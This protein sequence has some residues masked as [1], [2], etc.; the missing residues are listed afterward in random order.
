MQC[1]A[2]PLHTS[3]NHSH[4][5]WLTVSSGFIA[6]WKCKVCGQ[7]WSTAIS[8]RKKGTGCPFC[9]GRRP[10][11]GR[12]DL[13]TLRPDLATE[14][15]HDANE[16]DPDQ[17]TVSSGQKVF[18]K[19]KT[20]GQSWRATIA[21]RNILGH[22]CP[23][24]AGRRPIPGQTDLATLRPNLVEEWDYE[25]NEKGPEDYTVGSSL[26]VF[27]KCKTCKQS[28]SA[29]ISHRSS[30]MGCPY[31]TGQRKKHD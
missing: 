9:L 18:W 12:T 19:C 16:K 14:W 27:W 21:S 26:K 28:W 11:P 2:P 30:G 13:A 25:A 10:I 29:R 8:D 7:K 24:C 3:C 31:C 6:V 15:D 23:F 5:C 17:Y 20:C 4:A 1:R 22:R